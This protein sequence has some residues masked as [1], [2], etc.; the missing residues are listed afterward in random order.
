MQGGAPSATAPAELTVATD[1]AARGRYAIQPLAVA[2]VDAL[3]TH[4]PAVGCHYIMLSVRGAVH[5][6]L[7]MPHGAVARFLA[8]IAR[9]AR[10]VRTVADPNTYVVSGDAAG[11]LSA[12]LA[13][14]CADIALGGP[15]PGATTAAA[16]ERCRCD[17]CNCRLARS[18]CGKQLHAACTRQWHPSARLHYA[19][20]ALVWTRM[21]LAG[22]SA[23]CSRSIGAS[24]ASKR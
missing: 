24:T 11:P 8:V 23:P 9:H 16:R 22:S 15:A 5:L 7:Y 13:L 6:P 10:L 20:A 2:D 1:A 4:T 3:T 19:G 21:T 17:W 14:G 12:A 18:Q